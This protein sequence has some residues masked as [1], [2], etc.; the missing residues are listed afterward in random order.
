[1]AQAS[2]PA[3]VP[4]WGHKK[5]TFVGWKFDSSEHTHPMTRSVMQKLL[6]R[7]SGVVGSGGADSER[8]LRL[9]MAD[10]AKSEVSHAGRLVVIAAEDFCTS[11]AAL[12]L[13]I[14]AE[15]QIKARKSKDPAAALVATMPAMLAMMDT[16]VP[17]CRAVAMWAVSVLTDLEKGELQS[18]S[19]GELVRDFG[20][21]LKRGSAGLHR[22]GCIADWIAMSLP[23]TMAE[24]AAMG[25]E[26]CNAMTGAYNRMWELMLDRDE[27]THRPIKMLRGV[28]PTPSKNCLLAYTKDSRLFM[29]CAVWYAAAQPWCLLDFETA[30]AEFTLVDAMRDLQEIEE[31]QEAL[32]IPSFAF[33]KHTGKAMRY[34]DMFSAGGTFDIVS[35]TP[36]G[37]PW[38]HQTSEELRVNA[39]RLYT[40]AEDA[41]LARGVPLKM[42]VR[43]AGTGP[44]MLQMRSTIVSKR[45]SPSGTALFTRKRVAT[46]EV[47]E[48]SDILGITQAD[49]SA[50][51]DAVDGNVELIRDLTEEQWTRSGL[52]LP[53]SEVAWWFESEERARFFDRSE[54]GVPCV[55]LQKPTGAGKHPTAL[56]VHEGRGW[57]VKGPWYVF[58]DVAEKRR[59]AEDTRAHALA[60]LVLGSEFAAARARIEDRDVRGRRCIM[61]LS[62]A[63]VGS[64]SVAFER[65]V[66]E[67][68][69]GQVFKS[70][71]RLGP[72]SF[73]VATR[74]ALGVVRVSDALEGSGRGV[75]AW[76]REH[77]D[78]WKVM[79]LRMLLL[80]G[81]SGFY[82]VLVYGGG[83]K[84]ALVDGDDQRPQPLPAPGGASLR[85]LLLGMFSKALKREYL[86]AIHADAQIQADIQEAYGAVYESLVREGLVLV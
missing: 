14:Q 24:A 13:A 22:A 18:L 68:R 39:I 11:P 26:R 63:L 69:K 16:S 43:A 61:W 86:H 4:G 21:Q 17:R 45:M 7:G 54:E 72:A 58:D 28:S 52:L 82:N 3:F 27:R 83:C 55:L 67:A 66:E 65:I 10:A 85:R 19:S 84:V 60:R 47:R 5:P 46:S 78:V 48:V 12:A 57:I 1:M 73:V 9:Y 31:M 79:A 41:A 20:E 38:F 80:R 42:A 75:R 33:D 49:H 25:A 64:A 56:A 59:E 8:L 34:G 35:E 32:P 29:L 36:V 53:E 40:Q 30:N 62:P 77:S 15:R 23:T 71:S 37:P 76:L 50:V 51:R 2:K 74:A 6:R 44:R 81:D 70:A